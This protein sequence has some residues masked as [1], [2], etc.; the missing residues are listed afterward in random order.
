MAAHDYNTINK[1]ADDTVVVGL[2]TDN[3][4]PTYREVV[5][6]L[7]VC[8]QDNNLYLNVSKTRELIMDYR[9]RRGEHAP[10]P[11]DRAAVERVESFKLFSVHITK[12]LTC[13]THTHT[14]TLTDTY[15][16]TPT[17]TH[18]T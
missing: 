8:C 6:N 2:I 15:T 12:E 11:I 4:E 5:R 13:S 17:H 3:D 14:H 9:K 16:D 10:I 18:T 1:F 7:S